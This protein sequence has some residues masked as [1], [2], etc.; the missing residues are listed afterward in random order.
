M[1]AQQG[2]G[3]V[4]VPGRTVLYLSSAPAGAVAE[5]FAPL[6]SW[7]P[8]MFVSPT[9]PRARRSLARYELAESAEVLDLD[10]AAALGSL[11]LR[12]SE[13]VSSDR[14]VT[15]RWAGAIAGQRRW[16]GVR[17]WSYYDPRWYSYGL[18]DRR[19][20]TVTG[21]EPLSLDHPAVVEAATALRRP[22]G[23]L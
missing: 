3:R 17:W 11:G 18:W 1:P 5:V 9:Q 16:E 21:V 19:H 23:P 20:L 8:Q 2:G 15:Q 4:D 12:P 6:A 10:D 14:T 7:L 13:V 22:L